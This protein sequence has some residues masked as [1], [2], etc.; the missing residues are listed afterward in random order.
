[1]VFGYPADDVT[2]VS[3]LV[4]AI[5]TV[6]LAAAT[7]GLVFAAFKQLP[8]LT[9]QIK[10]ARESEIEINTITACGKYDTDPVLYEIHRRIWENSD[11]GTKYSRETIDQHDAIVMLNYL[12]GIA[13]G[14]KQGVLSNAITKDHLGAVYIKAVDIIIPALFGNF[15][16]YEAI[17][18]M[19]SGWKTPTPTAY[20]AQP[21]KP[22]SGS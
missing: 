17:E 2:A 8:L 21:L 20:T 14:V 6:L 4:L 19:R 12:D 10:M 3:T 13:I 15:E 11:K 1:M 5:G 18:E 7:A 22:S 16:G 9:A